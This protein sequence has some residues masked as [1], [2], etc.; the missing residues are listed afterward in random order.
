MRKPGNQP[1]VFSCCCFW[2]VINETLC[3]GALCRPSLQL[4]G[5]IG[6]M[7]LG[8]AGNEVVCQ[9]TP[10]NARSFLGKKVVEQFTPVNFS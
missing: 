1:D 7:L 9:Q 8:V 3:V 5:V 6:W 10:A 2:L 4:Q